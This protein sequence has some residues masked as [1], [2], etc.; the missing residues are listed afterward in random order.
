MNHGTVTSNEREP[1]AR[2]VL[3]HVNIRVMAVASSMTHAAM[4]GISDGN[5]MIEIATVDPSSAHHASEQD[6][7]KR[8]ADVLSD[9]AV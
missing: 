3:R 7:K 6:P 8:R 1:S 9:F 4:S 5:P 2:D